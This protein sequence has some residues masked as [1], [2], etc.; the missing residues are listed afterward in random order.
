MYSAQITR[1]LQQRTLE[2]LSLAGSGKI[3]KEEA[4]NIENLRDVLRFHEH[5]YYVQNDPLVSDPE[6]DQLFKLLQGI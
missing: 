6:Y 2:W 4:D 3:A 1:A 5:R